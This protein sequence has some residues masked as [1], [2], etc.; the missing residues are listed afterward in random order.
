MLGNQDSTIFIEAEVWESL[1]IL[2]ALV[3]NLHREYRF[4]K[5]QESIGMILL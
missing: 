1:E 2:G 5:D 3:S 4:T